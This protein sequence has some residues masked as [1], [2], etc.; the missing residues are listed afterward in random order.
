MRYFKETIHSVL[1]KNAG[2]CQY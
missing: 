1:S 2:H